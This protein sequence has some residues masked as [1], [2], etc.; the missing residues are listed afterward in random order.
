[1][2]SREYCPAILTHLSSIGFDLSIIIARWFIPLFSDVKIVSNSNVKNVPFS[3]L[4]R[5]WDYLLSYGFCGLFRI[6]VGLFRLYETEIMSCEIVTFSDLLNRISNEYLV[7]ESNVQR[8]FD[9]M[10]TLTTVGMCLRCDLDQL[11]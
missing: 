7:K 10:M 2:S 6:A 9:M 8:L 4:F 3:C 5:L 1:M 11:G